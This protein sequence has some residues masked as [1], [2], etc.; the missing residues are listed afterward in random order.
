VSRKLGAIQTTDEKSPMTTD[1]DQYRLIAETMRGIVAGFGGDEAKPFLL[2]W[3]DHPRR[4]D[5][6]ATVL[7][8]IAQLA[9]L[10]RC[11]IPDLTVLVDSFLHIA[12]YCNWRQTYSTDDLGNEFLKNYGWVD[13]IDAR[14]A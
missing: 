4:R 12:P 1:A 7:P 14:G 9:H 10:K 6:T 11:P 3:P 13:I 5:V 2:D 8:V